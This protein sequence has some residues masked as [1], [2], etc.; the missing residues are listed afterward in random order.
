MALAVLPGRNA[1]FLLQRTIACI[2]R[3][4]D[5]VRGILCAFE[6]IG[7]IACCQQCDR[8]RGNLDIG[9]GRDNRNEF[10]EQS[11]R[12]IFLDC[13]GIDQL[14]QQNNIDSVGLIFNLIAI[15]FDIF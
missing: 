6:L 7:S 5:L 10:V 15:T 8:L 11:L 1:E 2:C 12:G 13:S 9:L 4:I 3:S 14:L